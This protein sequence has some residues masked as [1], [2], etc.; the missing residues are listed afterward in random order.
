MQ[1]LILF[2]L[3]L[4]RIAISPLMAPR[5]RFYPSCS[6]YAHIAVE[7]H[8]AARG[9]CLAARRLARCH[10]WHPGG[11]DLVPEP[12]EPAVRSGAR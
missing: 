12:G 1:A 5:C 4:Y 9:I 7:R 6:E 10:P 8:G 3:R 11:I 2:L